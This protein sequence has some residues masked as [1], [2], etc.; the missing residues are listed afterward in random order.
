MY[1]TA[2]LD[3]SYTCSVC[4]PHKF[5]LKYLHGFLIALSLPRLSPILSCLASPRLASASVSVS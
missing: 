3:A 4:V 1:K 5:S 2:F